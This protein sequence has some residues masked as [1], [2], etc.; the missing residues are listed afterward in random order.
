MPAPNPDLLA[1]AKRTVENSH[2]QVIDAHRQVQA[3]RDSIARSQA[4]LAHLERTVRWVE[5]REE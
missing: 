1:Q 4:L 3:A 2:K 5:G